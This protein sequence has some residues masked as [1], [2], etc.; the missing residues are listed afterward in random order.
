MIIRSYIHQDAHELAEVI[1]SVCADVKWMLTKSFI[2]TD[3]WLHAMSK[4]ECKKHLLLVVEENNK[5]IG[6]CRVFP[7]KCSALMRS[8]ELGIGILAKYRNQGIG[9]S[10]I[11]YSFEWAQFQSLDQIDLSVSIKNKIALH[12][13]EKVGFEIRENKTNE[14]LLM[15]ANMNSTK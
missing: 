1:N 15:S 9:Y 12:L 3:E 7:K 14:F 2:P 5:M 13:F 11:Q 4:P 6:W 8:A 10:L